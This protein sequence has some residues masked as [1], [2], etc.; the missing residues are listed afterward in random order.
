M[1]LTNN[2]DMNIDIVNNLFNSDCNN[3]NEVRGY[4]MTSNTHSS[5]TISIS[6]SKCNEDYAT[7]VQRE[8][9]NMVE[10]DLVVITDSPQ[11]EYATPSSQPLWVSKASNPP[12]NARP[13]HVENT[14]PTLNNNCTDNG[15]VFNM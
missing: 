13:Q 10:D 2:T 8:S 14:Q 4:T 12:S 5:R 11:I 7:R 6:S 3:Y 1:T 9:N 15:N